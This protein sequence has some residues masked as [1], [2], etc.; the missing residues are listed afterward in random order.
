MNL[1]LTAAVALLPALAAAGWVAAVAD[2]ENR[3]VALELGS[4][5]TVFMLM[6]LSVGYDQPSFIDL[7][8]TVVLLSFPGALA[9]A[10]FLE[11][12]L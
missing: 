8:L 10:H 7:G 2:I 6:L 11:R 12:W 5:L 3:F 4:T 1:W 9:Y